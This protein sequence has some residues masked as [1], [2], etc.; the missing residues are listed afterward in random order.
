MI[1]S[2]LFMYHEAH[3]VFCFLY[4]VLQCN[5]D[6][7]TRWSRSSR[8]HLKCSNWKFFFL[9]Y[10]L[11]T[12]PIAG[13][14]WLLTHL[15]CSTCMPRTAGGTHRT[16]LLF[17]DDAAI[18]CLI[19]DTLPLTSYRQQIQF[20]GQRCEE[21]FLFSKKHRNWSLMWRQFIY[22]QMITHKCLGMNMNGLSCTVRLTMSVTGTSSG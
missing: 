4:P 7:C 3:C 20:F 9:F 22:N 11:E 5:D 17:S 10:F 1:C 12:K 18:L 16:M 19:S 14:Q 8:F 6:V 2:D 13:K 15:F 21:H